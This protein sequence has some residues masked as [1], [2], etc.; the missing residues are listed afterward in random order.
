M[1]KHMSDAELDKLQAWKAQGLS[2]TDMRRR[3]MSMRAAAR[4][5]GPSLMTIRRALRGSTFRRSKVETRGRKQ[6]LTPANLRALDR[7]RK[8]LIAKADGEYEV[9]WDDI[10]RAARVPSVDRTTAAKCLRAVGYDISWRSPRLKPARG[11]I[12]EE[13]RAWICNK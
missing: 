13:Q 9:H 8:R 2:L 3:L 6:I 10:V 12:D 11:E 1:G 5:R 7:A 4:E